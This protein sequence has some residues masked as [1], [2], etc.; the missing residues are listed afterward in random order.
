MIP[1][2]GDI[3]TPIDR[4]GYYLLIERMSADGDF[5]VLRLDKY[6]TGLYCIHPRYWRLVA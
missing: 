6:S 3:W 5:E 1:K 4:D 2:A